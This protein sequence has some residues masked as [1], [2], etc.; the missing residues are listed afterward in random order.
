MSQVMPPKSRPTY[1]SLRS[2]ISLAIVT[3]CAR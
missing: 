2:K 1:T 3:S